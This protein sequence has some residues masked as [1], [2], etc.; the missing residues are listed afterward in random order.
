MSFRHPFRPRSVNIF[1]GTTNDKS[2]AERGTA[3]ET[4][5]KMG[6]GKRKMKGN[7]IFLNARSTLPV[8]T[9]EQEPGVSARCFRDS[10]SF[11]LML[12]S[13]LLEVSVPGRAGWDTFS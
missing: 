5:G 6:E 1:Q 13:E 9:S 7:D 4:R 8:V 12:W 11:L 3:S 10:G 2:E